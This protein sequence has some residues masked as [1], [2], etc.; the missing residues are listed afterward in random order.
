M[1]ISLRAVTKENW[2]ECIKLQVTEDQQNF[3]APNVYSLAQ[4]YVEPA[5]IPLAI[6]DDE[7]M[8]GF[9]W[10]TEQPLEDGSYK[11][12]RIMIDQPYQ[13]KGYARM[14]LREVIERMRQIPGCREILMQ[15]FST[16]VVAAHLITS[17]GFES[18]SKA[19]H[20]MAYGEMDT[21]ITAQLRIFEERWQADHN[22]DLK[23]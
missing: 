10:Y 4:S 19:E 23:V 21:L 13:G 1:P 20:K 6:Y 16:N 7:T 15:Y 3:V 2:R 14:A 12:S 8:V 5:R 22:G 9:I 11:I 18:F 17:L